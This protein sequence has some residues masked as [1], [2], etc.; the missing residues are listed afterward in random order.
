MLEE[1]NF[2]PRVQE[3]I[4]KQVKTKFAISRVSLKGILKD[5]IREKESDPRWKVWDARRNEDLYTCIQ[6][7]IAATSIIAKK[8]KQPKCPA[9]D[10]YIENFIYPNNGMLF[11]HKKEWNIN[12]AIN[13]NYWKHYAKLSQAPKATYLIPLLWHV[14][15]RQTYWNRTIDL[16]LPVA[17]RMGKNGVTVNEYCIS[18]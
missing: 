15:K 16:W 12:H 4:F 2:W 18:F 11:S 7:F 13:I 17:E 10:E 8:G 6:M 5:A 1:N 9:T 14:Q 3:W